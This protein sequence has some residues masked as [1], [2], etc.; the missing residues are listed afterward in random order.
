MRGL[1][2]SYWPFPYYLRNIDAPT[3]YYTNESFLNDCSILSQRY[4]VL[5][6]DKDYELDCVGWEGQY[7]RLADHVEAKVWF[8]RR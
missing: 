1:L 4:K 7:H 8:P 3:D 2:D 5:V 6:L